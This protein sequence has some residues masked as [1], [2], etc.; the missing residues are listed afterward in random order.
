M[1]STT[2]QG[3]V[4]VLAM[5][6]GL[7]W[8]GALFKSRFVE[9]L[10][11]PD[12]RTSRADLILTG[13]GT[14][15][16]IAGMAV[17]LAGAY[18][19]D[20]LSWR[21]VVSYSLGILVLDTVFIILEV[22][23]F[24]KLSQKSRLWAAW[25]DGDASVRI[26]LVLTKAVYRDAVTF[27]FMLSGGEAAMIMLGHLAYIQRTKGAQAADTLGPIAAGLVAGS[28]A[29]VILLYYVTKL[30]SPANTLI[31]LCVRL[32]GSRHPRRGNS[33]FKATR[34]RSRSHQ[35]A[36][37]ITKY[38]ERNLQGVRR[39]LTSDQFE[40]VESAYRK[41]AHLIKVRSLS[42][43]YSTAT[44]MRFRI[45]TWMTLTLVVNDDPV[46]AARRINAVLRHES[47]AP[48][49]KNSLAVRILDT[50]NGQLQS[51]SRLLQVVLI[52]LFLLY[53]AASGQLNTTLDSI[54]KLLIH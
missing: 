30:A 36:F 8:I 17:I 44:Y 15:T 3:F 35:Q 45:L 7:N 33:N 19:P 51:Y 14:A 24:R 26:V 48:A 31:W 16:V 13:A 11:L 9:A 40:V 42:A 49:R 12:G 6:I 18:N 10:S 53:L 22:P 47:E 29:T 39:R 2:T 50:V 21:A 37:R 27:G 4:I 1:D 23:D 54:S 25:I 41:L 5:I 20:T 38:A 32:S 43:E 46:R 28:L 34:W 52:V